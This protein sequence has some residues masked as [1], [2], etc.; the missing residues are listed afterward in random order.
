VFR[1]VAQSFLNYSIQANSNL[2]RNLLDGTFADKQDVDV[3]VLFKFRTV[4]A[5]RRNQTQVLQNSRMQSVR[6]LTDF[7]R[8]LLHASA[9]S[10][11]LT[12][13][14]LIRRREPVQNDSNLD[15]QHG[16][17]LVQAI[18]K[19]PGDA[20]T[21]IFLCVD[22]PTRQ[23]DLLDFRSRI[24]RPGHDSKMAFRRF[25]EVGE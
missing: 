25:I 15:A 8:Q 20:S 18:V 7:F 3:P 1:C 6:N 2:G 4:A 14:G 9:N 17:R 11:Q 12:P 19:F 16:Q 5:Q 22:E 13:E 23:E 24:N 21:L 10:V